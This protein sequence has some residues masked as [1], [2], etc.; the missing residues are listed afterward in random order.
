MNPACIGLN[1]NIIGIHWK[2]NS[3]KKLKDEPP[4]NIRVN[5][6]PIQLCVCVPHLHEKMVAHRYQCI[7]K[8]MQH[9]SCCNNKDMNMHWRNSTLVFLLFSSFTIVDLVVL[10]IRD[11][12]DKVGR[13]CN[14]SVVEIKPEQVKTQGKVR[15]QSFYIVV[16][17]PFIPFHISS[18]FYLDT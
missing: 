18:T 13:F 2:R 3:I 12:G 15:T 9:G 14:P 4:T 7:A 8:P 1:D 16:S 11:I 6:Y 5:A 10:W 17:N